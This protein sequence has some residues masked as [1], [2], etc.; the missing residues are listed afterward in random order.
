MA[1]Q[2]TKTGKRRWRAPLL[3]AAGAVALALI[4]GIAPWSA[5]HIA[6]I[7]TG[8]KHS[9][10][11]V[12]YSVSQLGEA[13]CEWGRTFVP[14]PA[15]RA[16]LREGPPTDWS[17][18]A[19][20]PGAAFVGG[21]AVEVSIQG[22]SRRTITLTR[23]TFKVKGLGRRPSGLSFGGQC[24]GGAVGRY[25]VAD[26]DSAPPKLSRAESFFHYQR[27]RPI[28]FPW[29]VSLTDP[30]L[31][32]VGATTQ[33]CFC[34]WSAKIPWV[35]GARRGVIVVGDPNEGFRVTGDAGIRPYIEVGS[36]WKEP[37]KG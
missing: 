8:G 28:K 25:L 6:G 32:Y 30:L 26:L 27:V 4:G 14:E 23:I 15:A 10:E 3:A 12:S 31:L 29:T 13:P 11:L 1:K 36:S 34:E 17:D 2:P 22:E 24:G 35:S 16:V 19:S 18:L 5:D 7:V 20:H 33:S 37:A 9:A 21:S